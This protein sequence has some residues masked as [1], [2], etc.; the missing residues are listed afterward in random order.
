MKVVCVKTGDKYGPE[1]VNVL[2]SMVER[3]L[4]LPHQFICITDDPTGVYCKT[5]EPEGEN[6]GWWTKLTLFHDKCYGFSG[7]LLYFDLDVVIVDSINELAEFDSEFAII[8]DWNVPKTYNSSCFL[9]EV[10]SRTDVWTKY[11][12]DPVAARNFPGGDQSHITKYAKADLWPEDWFRSYKG[13]C[14]QAPSGKVVVFHGRPNPGELPNTWV[15]EQ[16]R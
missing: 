11:S 3:H 13:H 9:L 14:L 6:N 5:L 15:A 8:Q 12:E 7:K 2:Q 10:G 4:T 16:W 1:Y